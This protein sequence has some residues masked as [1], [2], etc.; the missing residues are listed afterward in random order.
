MRVVPAATCALQVSFARVQGRE[1]NMENLRDEK[2]IEKLLDRLWHGCLYDT[3]HTAR[4]SMI[5][6]VFFGLCLVLIQE[7]L[8]FRK[9]IIQDCLYLTV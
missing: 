4:D 8:V 9:R 1:Q 5:Q 7:G 3:F 2:F 6:D